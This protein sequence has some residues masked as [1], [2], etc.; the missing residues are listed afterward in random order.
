MPP[1]PPEAEYVYLLGL[2]LGDGCISRT[3][4]S[5]KIRFALDA[6][7]PGIVEECRRA[8]ETIRPGKSAWHAQRPRSRCI[9][10]VMYWNHWPCLI[11]QHGPGRKHERRIQLEPWQADLVSRQ[12]KKLLR[13]LIHSDGCRIVANDRGVRSIRYAF[14]NRS[15]DIKRIFCD[16]LDALGVTWTRPS[17]CQIAVYRKEA[18]ARL[19]EFIGPKR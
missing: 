6:A 11:P 5:Y 12:P 16:G 18:T 4:R 17:S 9:D 2:Y 10:V 1:T 13:G 15:E 14:S 7:Y 3:P 8:L 19:D